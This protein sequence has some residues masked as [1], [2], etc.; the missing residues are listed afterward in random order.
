M[1]PKYDKKI[2][3]D[4][5]KNQGGDVPYD[6]YLFGGFKKNCPLLNYKNAGH[7]VH[8]FSFTKYWKINTSAVKRN[9]K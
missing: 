8:L 7:I 1:T 3:T 4:L 5:G 9:R 6:I 2:I